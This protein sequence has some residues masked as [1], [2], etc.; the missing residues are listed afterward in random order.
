MAIARRCLKN[1]IEWDSPVLSAILPPSC[2]IKSRV[3]SPMPPRVSTE[4]GSKWKLGSRSLYLFRFFFSTEFATADTLFVPIAVQDGAS[5]WSQVT[6]QAK[7]LPADHGV[8]EIPSGFRLESRN[9]V[10]KLGSQFQIK[11]LKNDKRQKSLKCVVI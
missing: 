5:G 1:V 8:S 6:S 4:T 2:L 7:G 3:V 9:Q 11:C 10:E